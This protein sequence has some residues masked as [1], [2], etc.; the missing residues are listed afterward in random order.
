MN[1]LFSVGMAM[2]MVGGMCLLASGCTWRAA[3]GGG[4][5][6]AQVER[7]PT[8]EG[9]LALG[10]GYMTAKQFND[11]FIAY[12]QALLLDS[13][14][15]E[16]RC[17]LAEASLHLGDPHTALQ[18]AEGAL[19][20]RA[21]APTAV[22]LRGRARLA[23][24]DPTAALPDLEGAASA[25]ATQ[26][27]TRLALVSAYQAQRRPDLARN[28]AAKLAGQFPQE[29]RGHYV[30]ALLLSQGRQ[31][32]QAEHE[33][34]EALRLD[35]TLTNAKL[36]LAVVLVNEHKNY[37]E[38]ERLATEVDAA[39]PGDGSAAGLAAWAQFLSGK[40]EA[41]LRALI[42]AYQDHRYNVQIIRW[43]RDAALQ[44]GRIDLATAADKE[45]DEATRQAP[46]Q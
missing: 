39:V 3:L 34:R 45:I 11:A 2:A 24:G 17:G 36:E 26:F 14:S 37:E 4:D 7:H 8:P 25:D 41:G 10:Q 21:N 12:R 1:R 23:L 38:A 42:T 28:Q 15:F 22:G 30:Y 13:R 19:A 6:R 32:P 44:M 27:E 31:W 35:P 40:Q 33:Y 9:W 16:A 46:K 5:A 43:I 18:W 29:A 20:L